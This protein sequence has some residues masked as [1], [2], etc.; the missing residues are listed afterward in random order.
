M[1]GPAR[2]NQCASLP[3][4]GEMKVKVH[5]NVHVRIGVSYDC[6]LFF[7]LYIFILGTYLIRMM[8]H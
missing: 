2:V 1:M 8:L 5:H 3:S 7:S 6:F 4:S